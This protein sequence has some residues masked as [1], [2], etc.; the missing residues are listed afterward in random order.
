[1][2][3]VFFLMFYQNCELRTMHKLVPQFYFRN[4]LRNVLNAAAVCELDPSGAG[5]ALVKMF[6]ELISFHKRWDIS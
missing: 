2:R 1:M 6:S 4:A 5:Y 3:E